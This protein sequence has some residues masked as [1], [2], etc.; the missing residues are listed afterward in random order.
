MTF[1]INSIKHI[2]RKPLIDIENPPLFLII[3]GYGSNEKDLF[4]ISKDLPEDFF[5]ISLQALYPLEFGG[6]AWYDIDFSKKNLSINIEQA[7]KSREKIVSFIEEAIKYY[8]LNENDIW[9]CGFSQGAILNYSISFYYPEKI[10]KVII[11]SGFPH[12]NLL[13][14]VIKKSNNLL[15]FFIS[16]GKYDNIIPIEIA[17]KGPDLLKY[18]KI[19]YSYKEYDSEHKLNASNYEDLIQWIK[20]YRT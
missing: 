6:F 4:F 18:Y 8:H 16:H 14:K 3:H 17:K 20:N 5:V 1:N 19:S 9:I 7:I 10:N 15:N 11:L 12:E 2:I 13:P